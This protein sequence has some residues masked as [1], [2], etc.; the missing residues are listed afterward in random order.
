MANERCG[1]DLEESDLY[2]VQD[3]IKTSQWMIG[4]YVRRGKS[5]KEIGLHCTVSNLFNMSGDFSVSSHEGQSPAIHVG[6]IMTQDS[7]DESTRLPNNQ[8][9][10]VQYYKLK[11]R[12]IPRRIK[13]KFL[14]LI[15]H[16]AGGDGQ[17]GGAQSTS[18]KY[19]SLTNSMHA[20]LP[21]RWSLQKYPQ[22]KVSHS[23]PSI[24]GRQRSVNAQYSLYV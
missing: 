11:H 10:F 14:R 5:Q 24:T 9:L 1:L 21:G 7:I 6:P 8:C 15:N 19:P 23:R 12:S 20:K 16:K 2:F 4:S 22:N 17:T 13:D 18:G 3:T